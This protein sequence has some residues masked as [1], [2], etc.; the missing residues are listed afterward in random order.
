MD[1]IDLSVL[2]VF[3]TE[4]RELLLK[5]LERIYNSIQ[6]ISFEVVIVN[7]GGV[8]ID[9]LYKKFKNLK[10]VK[11]ITN[12]GAG[13]ARNQCFLESRGKVVLFM[14]PDLFVV[15]ATIEKMYKHLIEHEEIDGLSTKIVLKDGRLAYNFGYLPSLKYPFYEFFN[16]LEGRKKLLDKILKHNHLQQV[17]FLGGGGIMLRR[18]ALYK[19]GLYDEKF[20][21]GWDDTDWC[22]R[23]KRK[24]VKLF[25]Y[26]PYEDENM[27]F[28]HL[29]HQAVKHTHGRQ[30][31]FYVSEIYYFKKHYG[32]VIS[33][34]IKLFI[35]IFSLLHIFVS[36]LKPRKAETRRIYWKLIRKIW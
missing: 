10:I 2:I 9:E 15:D 35:I 24:G 6:H 1:E 25:Y 13:K 31:D 21:Y 30:V 33:F 36:F 12:L 8:D 7:N 28:I 16:I 3:S 34:I 4:E 5:C 27:K 18:E 14:E 26:Y 20:I 17:E 32:W 29:L 19:V 11:N 22:Y 23:A